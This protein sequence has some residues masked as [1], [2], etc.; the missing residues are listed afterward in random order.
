MERRKGNVGL[1][2]READ[3]VSLAA[4]VFDAQLEEL[5]DYKRLVDLLVEKNLK[6]GIFLVN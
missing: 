6:K 5:V 3:D 1:G 4:E 2:A